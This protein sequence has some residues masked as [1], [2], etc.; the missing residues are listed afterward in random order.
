MVGIDEAQFFDSGPIDVCN[1][2]ANNGIR[3]IVA[4]LDMD[5]RGIPFGPC[6]TVCHCRRSFKVHAIC[7]KCGPASFSPTAPSRTTNKYCWEKPKNMNLY[8][9]SAISKP[10]LRPKQITVINEYKNRALW[11]AKRL[12]FRQFYPRCHFGVIIIGILMLFKTRLS[13]VLLPFFIA[14]AH[15]LSDI[16]LV[17]FF[18]ATD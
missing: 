3:V 9:G 12:S 8:A 7:V 14:L 11:N 5:F 17:T 6:R 1:Q 2:L 16:P 10:S 15:C 13:G 18:Q 4:G